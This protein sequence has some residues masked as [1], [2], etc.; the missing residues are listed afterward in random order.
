MELKMVADAATGIFLHFEI[1]KGK[2]IM[3][4][5]EFVNEMKGT[6]ACTKR[7]VIRTQSPSNEAANTN[8]LANTKNVRNNKKIWIGNSWFTLVS[9]VENISNVAEYISIIKTGH[10]NY[11]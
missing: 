11:P 7:L 6:A 10:F 5:A 1:Q 4:T 9:A 3:A 8:E 2:H